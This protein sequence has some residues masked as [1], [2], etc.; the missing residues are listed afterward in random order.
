VYDDRDV[1]RE[2]L[3]FLHTQGDQIHRIIFPLH[4]DSFHF[5]PFDPRD[6]S[7]HMIPV[8][9]HQS[10]LQGIGVMYRVIDTEGIFRLLRSHDFNG[11]N[12]RLK[13]TLRDTFLPQNAGS[14][15]VHFKNGLPVLARTENAD[16]EI[17]MDIADFSSL[18]MGA[19][20]YKSLFGYGL[21]DI[22]EKKY[23]D[24]VHDIFRVDSKPICHTVF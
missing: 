3:T 12:C 17:S 16:V 1:L 20:G 24:V 4:D 7:G 10:N 19:V 9:S 6:G 13:I 21:S 2:L 15:T 22:S 11:Q 18:I 23:L 8:I 5:L 14:L